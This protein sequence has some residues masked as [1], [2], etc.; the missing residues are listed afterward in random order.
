VTDL[1]IRPYHASDLDRCRELWTEL[2]QYHRDIY[3]DPSIGG[4]TPGQY[5]DK[6]LARAGAERLWVA[7]L[8]GQVVGLTGLVVDGQ[9]AELEPLVVAAPYR[10]TGIGRAL[11]DH[12]I[13]E[14]RKL[15]VLYLSVRPVARNSDAISFFF[16]GGFRTLGHIELFMDLNPP[17]ADP[18]K[19]GPTLFGHRFKY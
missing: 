15:N 5:F 10:G 17:T 19:P 3:A 9:E 8:S 6:H 14:A 13:Q 4:A 1:T 16:N 11:T 12:A 2:T 18:W 7:E